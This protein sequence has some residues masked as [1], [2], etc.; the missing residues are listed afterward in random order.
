MV[1]DQDYVAI[2]HSI[3]RVLRA[4]QLLKQAGVAFLLIPVPRQLT[5]DCGLALRIAPPQL[6]AAYAVLAAAA[7]LPPE[8]YRLC[9][10][11]FVAAD[12]PIAGGAPGT[13]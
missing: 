8:L 5:A 6:T 3:H 13:T 2:F 7:L 11:E 1:N 12:P 9:A 4:E 10:G